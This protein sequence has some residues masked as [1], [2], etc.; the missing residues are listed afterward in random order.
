MTFVV[1]CYDEKVA[2]TKEFTFIGDRNHRT[3]REHVDETKE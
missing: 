2:R 3:R 1:F